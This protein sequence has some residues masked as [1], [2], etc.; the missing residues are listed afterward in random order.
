MEIRSHKHQKTQYHNPE[1]TF[2]TRDYFRQ[3]K[4]EMPK[5]KE[6]EIQYAYVGSY[7]FLT[8]SPWPN[9]TDLANQGRWVSLS[10]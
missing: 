4:F 2:G 7:F 3:H 8:Q 9:R 6:K 1:S 10:G 5:G